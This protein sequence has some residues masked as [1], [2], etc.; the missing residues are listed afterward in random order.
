MN[1]YIL[2]V[3]LAIILLTITLPSAGQVNPVRNT[4][5]NGVNI[6]ITKEAAPKVSIGMVLPEELPEFSTVFFRDLRLSGYFDPQ[7]LKREAVE[8]WQGIYVIAEKVS[9]SIVEVKVFSSGKELTRIKAVSS[10]E[11]TL[12][13][14]VS[15][16]VIRLLTGQPSI[17]FTRIVAS[18]KSGKAR[19][20]VLMDYDGGRVFP[21]TRDKSLNRYPRLSPD[22][23]SVLYTSHVNY[24]PV[25]YRQEIVSGTRKKVVSYPGLNS[26]AS[27][28]PT[29]DRIALSLSKDG[30]PEIYLLNLKSEEL[31][32]LTKEDG[33]DTSPI[34]F[35]DGKSLT[36]VS[37]RTGSP[38]VYRLDLAT[39]RSKRLTFEG[40]YN[41]SPAV[42]PDERFLVYTSRI[43]GQFEIRII[44]LETGQDF[45]LEAGPN[46]KEDPV[47]A[48]DSR[49]LVF[50][51]TRNYESN[52]KMLDI[53]TGD[54]YNITLDGGYGTPDWR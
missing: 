27:F 39:G 9:P 40:S 1:K 22:G 45:V 37:D 13:H 23:R 32:R 18:R 33:A 29:G 8:V 46:N 36:F 7:I 30:N 3:F 42:S 2:R 26:A 44:F 53:F 43:G 21:L 35:P 34:F 28:S 48:P 10:N 12:A 52:L 11:R 24:W 6:E 5:S 14:K 41:T 38:Q 17:V 31:T 47:F 25:V 15:D 4:I 19:E 51:H 20:L 49:H 54:L 50:T 16:E